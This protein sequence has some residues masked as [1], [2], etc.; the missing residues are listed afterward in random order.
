MAAP[1]LARLAKSSMSK[2]PG[3]LYTNFSPFSLFSIFTRSGDSEGCSSLARRM[4]Q[5]AVLLRLTFGLF[6]LFGQGSLKLV[7]SVE[8]YL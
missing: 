6:R 2:G 3:V 1:L 7:I 4:K 5:S 8:T